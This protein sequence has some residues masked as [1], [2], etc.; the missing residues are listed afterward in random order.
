MTDAKKLAVTDNAPRFIWPVKLSE[1]EKTSRIPV[2]VTGA[3]VKDGGKFSLALAD[4]QSMI[5]NFGKRQNKEIN[6]DYDH[7]SEQPEVG[8]G[9]AIP[10]AGRILRLED[11]QPFEGNRWILFGHYEPTDRARDLINGREYRYISPAI[12]KRA[13]DKATGDAQG[14]TLT[15]VALTN[16]PFLEEMPE[17][18]LSDQGFKFVQEKPDRPVRN[19]GGRR[20]QLNEGDNMAKKLSMKSAADGSHQVFDG[21]ELLGEVD[22]K[23]IQS[24]AKNHLKMS[25]AGA[26]PAVK[27]SEETQASVF[28]EIGATGQSAAQVRET[29][30]FAE[31]ARKA[32]KTREGRALLSEIYLSD[33]VDE[34]KADALLSAG[35]VEL[36][37]LRAAERA[38]KRV[39][40]A[41]AAGKILPIDRA[42]AFNEA[43]ERPAKFDEWIAKRPAVNRTSSTGATRSIVG[44]EGGNA[45]QQFSELVNLKV[46]ELMS[47]SPK[48]GRA[49]ALAE[50]GELVRKEQPE[51]AARRRAEEERK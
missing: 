38:R 20:N 19:G 50:A 8:R 40:D 17:V 34:D 23:E 26:N 33:K 49:R 5:E 44:A 7:A 22:S 28:S 18:Y 47:A 51:L 41:F 27:S 46:T 39:D 14:T 36:T 2:A 32:Q 3:W 30:Q 37:D 12:D 43:F 21:D 1:G 4:L 31:G 25:E 42:I 15:T 29:L 48:M 10:S 9:D 6:V 16:R 45:R 11:P 13:K 24:Y 35:S